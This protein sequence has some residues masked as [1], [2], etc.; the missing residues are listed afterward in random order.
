MLASF[1]AAAAIAANHVVLGASSATPSLL[2]FSKTAANEKGWSVAATE[3]SAIFTNGSLSD[4]NTLVFVST[5]GNFL[6]SDESNALKDFLLNGGSWLG[7]HAAGDFGDDMPTW[8]NQLVGG[9]FRS[10]PCETE[11]ICDDA[12]RARYPPSGNIR[13]D[14]VNIRD[15]NHPSTYDLPEIYNRTDEWYAYKTNPIEEPTYTVVATVEETY[16]DEITPAELQHMPPA[17][18]ISWYSTYEGVAR[19][20]YTGMGHTN[21]SYSEEYF[22]KHVTGALEWV[23]DTFEESTIKK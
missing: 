17:H 12:Q 7:I 4:F 6:S 21:E 9:Q 13:P 14:I 3:D 8:F 18:P 5:T 2:V 20:F 23:T 10:H 1:I 19:A 11:D 15:F 16:I 22:I